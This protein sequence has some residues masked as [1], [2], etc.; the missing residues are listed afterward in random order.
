MPAAGYAVQ[1][2][3]VTDLQPPTHSGS[4]VT[5]PQRIRLPWAGQTGT[6]LS[7]GGSPDDDQS[8]EQVAG[9]PGEHPP[10]LSPGPLW[11]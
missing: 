7:V 5:C 10:A 4:Q 2:P 9:S 11:P 3:V 1:V 6:A 8:Q